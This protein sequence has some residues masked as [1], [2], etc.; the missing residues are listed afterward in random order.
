MR[1]DWPVKSLSNRTRSR[2]NFPDSIIVMKLQIE[3]S[4]I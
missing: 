2:Q 1:K 3:A 4:V